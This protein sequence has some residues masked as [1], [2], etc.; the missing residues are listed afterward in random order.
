MVLA[1]SGNDM[2]ITARISSETL[3]IDKKDRNSN[4]SKWIEDM[5][6]KTKFKTHLEKWGVFLFQLSWN[7]CGMKRD[8]CT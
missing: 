8:V 2:G 7:M 4:G 3:R 5:E 6:E 1:M